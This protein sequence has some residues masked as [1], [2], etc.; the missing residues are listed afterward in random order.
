MRASQAALCSGDGKGYPGAPTSEIVYSSLVTLVRYGTG[1]T[2]A[3]A[4]GA[5]ADLAACR[6][7]ASGG[8]STQLSEAR[9]AT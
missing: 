1:R 3:S 9:N 6:A 4:S 7:E 5:E 8:R 2:A